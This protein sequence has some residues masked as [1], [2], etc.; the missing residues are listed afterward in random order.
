MKGASHRGEDARTQSAAK[1]DMNE[2][3]RVVSYGWLYWQKTPSGSVKQTKTI[4]RLSEGQSLTAATVEP[5]KPST[6]CRSEC[7][8]LENLARQIY[9][10]AL[11]PD[12]KR[13]P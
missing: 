5:N 13:S 10:T 4:S 1:G 11:N 6:R 7:G 9:T 8:A 2:Q 12:A 3:A